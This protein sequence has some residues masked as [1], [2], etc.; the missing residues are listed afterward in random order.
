MPNPRFDFRANVDQVEGWEW[1]Y[2]E[3][4]TLAVNLDDEGH[5]D[6]STTGTVDWAPWDTSQ[7][8]TY[9]SFNLW[10]VYDIQPGDEVS[11]SGSTVT[12]KTTVT[13]LAITSFDMD[14][15]TVSG[16][17]ASGTRLDVWVCNQTNC[18]YRHENADVDKTWFADFS[19][20][21]DEGDE[22]KT[23]DIARDTWINSQQVDE[24]GDRTMFGD[25]SPNFIETHPQYDEINARGWLRG[26]VLTMTISGLGNNY[27]ATATM[28]Q[29]PWNPGDPYDVIAIFPMDGFDLLSGHEI[30]I[31]GGDMTKT[32]R[33]ADPQVS[34]FDIEADT[35]SG[36]GTPGTRVQVCA[37]IPDSC[38]SRN[39][40]VDE[41]GK[42]DC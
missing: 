20:P 27:S 28:D 9:I 33:V 29:A 16:I 26:T 18:F 15:D 19:I 7:T 36:T 10:G 31:S 38:I 3:D 1:T 11:L 24:D 39:T 32:Y 6:Y 5:S 25:V 23:I 8:Q 40:E 35:I 22:D 41:L 42:L 17:A 4:V 30:T 34:N 37:Q 12:K 21:G 13:D 14:A 2:G